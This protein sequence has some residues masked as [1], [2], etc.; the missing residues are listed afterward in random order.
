MKKLLLLLLIPF[1]VYA[2][3]PTKPITVLAPS[4]PGAGGELSARAALSQLEA[5]GKVKFVFGNMPG[6]DGNLMIKHL[7]ES[8]PDG[9]TLG[10]P[11]CQSGFVFSEVLYSDVLKS[12]PFNLTLISGIGKSPMAFVANSKSPVNSIPELITAV[13]KEKRDINFAVGG[14]AHQLTWE[15]FM[16]KIGGDKDRVRTVLYKGPMPAAIDTA[17]GITEFGIMPVAVARPL[18]E[19]G[20]VKLLGIASER[21]VKNVP[22]SVALMKNY[23]PGLNVYGCWTFAL[24]PNTPSEIVKWYVENVIPTLKTQKYKDFMDENDIFLDEA[25]LSPDGIRK[26]LTTLRNQWLP[27][28]LKIPR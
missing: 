24:P 28:A 16:D 5:T 14:M 8:A 15:Y 9:Y 18:I 2:W 27:Y 20:R 11:S 22:K 12:S 23:A 25:T 10:L 4:A 17:G 7:M 1:S 19:S 13:T 6:A 26:D 3:E 21:Y